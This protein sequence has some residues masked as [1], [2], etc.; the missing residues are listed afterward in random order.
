MREAAG[1]LVKSSLLSHHHIQGGPPT[2]RTVKSYE[3]ASA[4]IQWL[5]RLANVVQVCMCVRMCLCVYMLSLHQKG[6]AGGLDNAP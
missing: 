4:E 1:F 5:I 2:F 6:P 3:K